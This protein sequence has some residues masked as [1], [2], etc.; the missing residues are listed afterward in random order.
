M[1]ELKKNSS[2]A[3]TSHQKSKLPK[4]RADQLFEYLPPKLKTRIIDRIENSKKDPQTKLF[5]F[6][7]ERKVKAGQLFEEIRSAQI[8]LGKYEQKLFSGRAPVRFSPFVVCPLDI[9]LVSDITP[10]DKII[11]LIL[12]RHSQDKKTSWPSQQ[13]IS[14]ESHVSIRTVQRSL[15]NLSK[16]GYLIIQLKR[17]HGHRFINHYILN[18]DDISQRSKK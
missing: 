1:T 2:P 5:S 17:I 8:E 16:H 7:R 12:F 18:I 6:I 10:L 4:A 15:T 14:D 13:K 9:L 3:G 11:F